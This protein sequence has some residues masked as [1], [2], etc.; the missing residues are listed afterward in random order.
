ME[1]VMEKLNLAK[2]DQLMNV[3]ENAYI[4]MYKMCNE[5][6]KIIKIIKN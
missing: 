1:D 2:N 6:N 5:T 4:D 3:K